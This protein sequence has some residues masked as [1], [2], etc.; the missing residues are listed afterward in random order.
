MW[1]TSRLCDRKE[2]TINTYLLI[3]TYSEETSETG[4]FGGGVRTEEGGDLALYTLV[5]I[6]NFEPCDCITYSK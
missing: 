3:Y 4:C 2:E 6:L 5:Y 1:H